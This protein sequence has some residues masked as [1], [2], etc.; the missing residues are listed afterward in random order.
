MPCRPRSGWA[1]KRAPRARKVPDYFLG[2][3]ARPP[4]RM[5]REFAFAG[6]ILALVSNFA[7]AKLTPYCRELKGKRYDDEIY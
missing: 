3:N 6:S 5:A 7:S 2:N 4:F 1:K